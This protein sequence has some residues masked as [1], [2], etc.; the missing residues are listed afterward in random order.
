MAFMTD[1]DLA[2]LRSELGAAPDEDTLIEAFDRLGNAPAVALDVLRGRLS[3]L[4]S[5]PASFS[6]SGEYS[7]S[8]EANIR[9][10]QAATDRLRQEVASAALPVAEQSRLVRADRAR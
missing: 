8:N 2:Y 1:A 5:G 4:V 3:E 9:A 7:E 6:I 10:L